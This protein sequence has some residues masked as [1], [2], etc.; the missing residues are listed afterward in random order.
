MYFYLDFL[1]LWFG[2]RFQE[3]FLTCV[4]FCESTAVSE[5]RVC[6]TGLLGS[7]ET[8]M[9]QDNALVVR[10]S[11]ESFMTPRPKWHPARTSSSVSDKRYVPYHPVVRFRSPKLDYE[12]PT[13]K[14]PRRFEG[15][16]AECSYTMRT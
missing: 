5:A 6:L 8:A 1:L 4:Q 16:N 15:K 7:S 13:L 11:V 10:R 2:M 14:Y 9:L 12:C 3:H